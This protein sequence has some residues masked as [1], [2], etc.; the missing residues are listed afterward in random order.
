M[1]SLQPTKDRPAAEPPVSR[2]RCRR[3]PS[4]HFLWFVVALCVFA[5]CAGGGLAVNGPEGKTVDAAVAERPVVVLLLVDRLAVGDLLD[6]SLPAVRAAASRGGVGLLNARVGSGRNPG[7]GYL[8]LG[9]GERAVTG[10]AS[11]LAFR[12]DEAYQGRD[13]DALYRTLT[14]RQDEGAAVLHL[15]IAELVA[16]AKEARERPFE[17][18]RL[19]RLLREA[20]IPVRVYGNADTPGTPRRFGALVAM[21]PDG[22]VPAG[23]VSASLLVD[24][25]AWPFGSRTDYDALL[26]VLRSHRDDPGLVV[27]DL[28]D[29]ARLEELA[30]YLTPEQA[31]ALRRETLARIDRF[32]AELIAGWEG[33]TRPHHLL[34]VVPQPDAP[35]NAAGYLLTPVVMATFGS[36]GEGV[37]APGLII[38]PTTRRDG[39][40]ANTDVLPTLLAFFGLEAEGLGGR[41][42]RVV[43]TEDAWERLSV[44]YEQVTRTH[45]Q[46]LPVIQPYFF[47]QLAAVL[48]SLALLFARSRLGG[49]LPSFVEASRWLH[50]ALVAFPLA[51]L[52]VP[53]FPPSDTLFGVWLRILAVT[54]AAALIGGVAGRRNP[55]LGFTLLALLTAGALVIDVATGARLMQQSH[56][57]YDPIGGS[58]YYGIGNEYMGVLIGM[59]AMGAGGLL[60]VTVGGRSGR[61][62]GILICAGVLFAVVT[63]VMAAPALGINFGGTVAAVVGLGSTLAFYVKGRLD[64]RSGLLILLALGCVVAA[65]GWYESGVPAAERS[66][67]GSAVQQ[68]AGEGADPLWTLFERKL[69]VN[70]RLIR[71]TIWSRAF[72]ISLL[73]AALLMVYPPRLIRRF[74][75]TYPY[76]GLAVKGS[77][78][79]AL[80]ALVVNDSGIVAAA[81][82]MIPVIS[83]LL[84]LVL[85]LAAEGEGRDSTGQN[86]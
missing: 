52:L 11:G 22:R 30:A 58:R 79:A 37:D 21:D 15:G 57:G 25:P 6:D 44:L 68:V 40:A 5:A 13:V 32:V 27:V 85:R 51:L 65:L 42:L 34:L 46:R 16:V 29:L 45:R 18:G 31:L 75:A 3:L 1:R 73:A 63:F 64:R 41:G 9:A 59:T 33:V 80:T 61:R 14:G 48:G 4:L 8:T 84:D 54:G 49:R 83:I 19:G 62:R 69:A 39:L 2:E 81:T 67:V 60:D 20:G 28:G 55:A 56:L 47:V 17:P 77:M 70:V 7:A 50:L 82:L 78:I 86:E 23:D 76:L 36:G 12:R 66:H 43:P 35:A 72:F 26:D 24:D 10:E 71:L 38:S 74:F 53:L